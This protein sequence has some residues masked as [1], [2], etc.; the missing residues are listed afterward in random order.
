VSV[1]VA[2]DELA[3]R[4]EEFGAY[5]FLVTAGAEGRPHVTSITARFDG[6]Q[7]LFGAGKTSLANIQAGRSLTLLW[8]AVGGPYCLIVD[9]T[10]RISGEDVTLTPTRA[11]LHRLADAP[12][13]LPSCIRIEPS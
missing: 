4:V 12:A 13:D 5:P 10:G 6:A 2:L 7:F 8:S 3:R 9:G 1:S 11:V